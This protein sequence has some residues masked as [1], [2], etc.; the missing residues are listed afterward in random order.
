MRRLLFFGLFLLCFLAG[1]VFTQAGRYRDVFRSVC[2]LTADH[3]YKDNQRLRNWVKV[4]SSKAAHVPLTASAD[5]LLQQISDQM[6]ELNVSHFAVY[7]P[8]E[9]RKLWKGESIDTGIRSRYV[10]EHLLIYKVL[11]GSSAQKAGLRAGDE[12]VKLPDVEQVSPWGAEHRAGPFTVKRGAEVLQVHVAPSSLNI[13]S[14]PAVQ[15]L[16]GGAGLLTIS[17]FRSEFFEEKEWRKIAAVLPSYR[18]IV[19]DIRENA[20]GNFVAMLRALSTFDCGGRLIGHLV[21]PRKA[22]P[23]KEA[24][25]DITADLHQLEELDKYHSLGL[26]TFSGY[27]CFRGRVTVLISSET[28]S[29]AEI[30]ADSFRGRGHSRVWGQPSAGD[31]VLAVWYDL[32]GMGPGYS[33]S[34]PEAVYLNAAKRELEG[35]GVAPEH[36]LYYDLK[37]SLAGKDSWV[38]EALR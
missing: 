18:H 29:V 31:V 30:F 37:T 27:G 35:G 10:E 14:S 12:I 13:D 36:E 24:F 20:G 38:L 33:V 26:Q 16:G 23:N 21:Q 22:G 17:S 28:S 19:I 3:F 5:S 2:D 8:A 15:P 25:D 7:S 1:L 34:I 32:P 4:C 9:D 6:S 11:P